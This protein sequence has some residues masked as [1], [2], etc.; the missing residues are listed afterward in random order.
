MFLGFYGKNTGKFKNIFEKLQKIKLRAI[1]Y[2]LRK[3]LIMAI[4]TKN[5]NIQD[6]ILGDLKFIPYSNLSTRVYMGC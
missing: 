4:D 2:E 6:L 3:G 5:Q 1:N